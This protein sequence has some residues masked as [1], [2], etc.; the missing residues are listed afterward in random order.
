[1]ACLEW[2][3]AM[4][5]SFRADDYEPAGPS[6][7]ATPYNL[8]H[9]ILTEAQLATGNISATQRFALRADPRMTR[10]YTLAAVDPELT[11]AAALLSAGSAAN[12]KPTN[13]DPKSLRVAQ[14]GRKQ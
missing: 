9:S 11:R 6:I 12:K 1:M 14:N 5:R 7:L 3:P 10:R 2:S 13:R 8:R 4:I